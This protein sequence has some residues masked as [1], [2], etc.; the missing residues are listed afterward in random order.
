M[1]VIPRQWCAAKHSRL[2]HEGC[3]HEVI[4]YKGGWIDNP[5]RLKSYGY[6]WDEKENDWAFNENGHRID[7][8]G[9]ISAAH[10]N[11]LTFNMPQ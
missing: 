4:K 6:I 8:P 1:N 11:A 2:G 3:Y 10:G 7:I 5:R 9:W